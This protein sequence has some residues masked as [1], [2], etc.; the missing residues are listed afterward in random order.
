MVDL[1]GGSIDCRSEQ[2]K[3]TTFTVVLDLPIAERQREDMTLDPMNVLIVD[4]DEIFLETT[5]D[6]LRSLG[7]TADCAG[8]GSDAVGM[9]AHR[10]ETGQDY[11]VVILD[12]KMPGVDGVETIRR[13][14]AGGRRRG[15]G[16]RGRS[17]RS[18]PR[19]RG[20]G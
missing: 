3:G 15:D 6:T 17:W 5:A 18:G 20:G 12:W 1:M 19:G 13:I 8:S 2:G 16:G 9:I 11:S 4:D 14:R 10:H 7:V